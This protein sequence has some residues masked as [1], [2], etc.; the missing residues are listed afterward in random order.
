MKTSGNTVVI[1]GA[2]SGIG[3][4]LARQ[5]SALNNTVIA[6]GRDPAK[7]ERA[8]SSVSGLRTLACDITDESAI[9]QAVSTLTAD[10]PALNVLVNA[11]GTSRP[12]R[13]AE[14]DAA[15]RIAREE[16]NT[17]LL[18]TFMMT[19]LALPPLLAR[20]EAAV[21]TISSGVAYAPHL[22]E[23]SHSA[24]KAALHALCR[25]LRHQLRN[26]P[27]KVFEVLPPLT[28]TPNTRAIAGK[29]LSPAAVAKSV[30]AGLESDTY[31]IRVAQVKALYFLNRLSPALAANIVTNSA[32][33]SG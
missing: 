5:L 3:L 4:E 15:I 30:I 10:F 29:K 23:P 27:V 11:A 22:D 17:N 21:V 12:Y 19:K 24:T 20:T 26:T 32:K 14:D 31:E 8:K 18:G 7:L 6:I 1:T 9:R 28:D 16:I 33:A 25:C 13:F 2:S